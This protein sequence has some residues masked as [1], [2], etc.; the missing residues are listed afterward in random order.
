MAFTH[1]DTGVTLHLE[2][3]VTVSLQ[4]GPNNYATK[5]TVEAAAWLRDKK[6]TWV[7]FDG[8]SDDGAGVGWLDADDVARFI[9][10]ASNH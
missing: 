5:H 1:T 8:F 10:A 4:W 9:D 2:N 7:T 3:N 6:R